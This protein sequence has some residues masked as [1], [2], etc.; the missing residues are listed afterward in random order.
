MHTHPLEH[1]HKRLL[2]SINPF[3]KKDPWKNFLDTLVYPV[4]LLG[5]FALIPQVAQIWIQK[6]TVGIA[7]ST[8]SMFICI[9]FFWILYGN[10]HKAK[11]IQITSTI[12]FSM[13]A[14]II[15]GYVLYS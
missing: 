13:Y 14:L 15:I 11:N 2:E 6:N 10:A 8:W 1:H 7:I 9:S 3:A 4:G 12:S 5:P